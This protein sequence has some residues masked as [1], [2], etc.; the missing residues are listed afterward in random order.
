MPS[1]A[2]FRSISRLLI[3][4]IVVLALLCAV[5]LG[6]MQAL[7][8]WRFQQERFDRDVRVLAENSLKLLSTALWDIETLAVQNQV[9][10][11]A[12]LPEV[13]HVHVRS[14]TG[15]V[16]EA[17][18]QAC[19]AGKPAMV[20]LPI[21]AP[22]AR[23]V[24]GELEI[25]GN[26]DSF[27]AQALRRVFYLLGGYVVF[28]LLVC[29]MVAW[30]LRRQLQDPLEQMRRFVADLRPQALSTPLNLVR[31]H[32]SYTDEID[33]MARGFQRLQESVRRHIVLLDA[34]VLERTVQLEA[35]V[36]EVRRLSML[37]A[38]TGCYNRRAL[39]ERLPAEVERSHRYQRP[40][41]VVFLDVDHFKRINDELGHVS[42]D[43]VLR[44]I[45]QR[46]M[47][48]LR[49]QV[50]WVARYGG[51]EFVIVLP[52]SD[53]QAAWAFAER[54]RSRIRSTPI[55][56]VRAQTIT[57]SLGVAQLRAEESMADLLARAD[58]LLYQAKKEGRDRVLGASRHG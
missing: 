2:P 6:G 21:L 27:A 38:L 7:I 40:L 51:E 54:L 32:S 26:T 3:Q 50:D 12:H 15:P 44:E 55:V 31:R 30:V 34:R 18:D 8:E 52:E 35:S 16:F 43:A 33:V 37:D 13:G 48:S 9:D 49:S 53:A 20:V 25:W 23:T 4:R 47:Q 29:S 11:L 22:E 5:L 36:E 28:T 56:V 45:A 58:A 42:G 19:E 14:L 10:W 46:C 39:D 41:S 17:G 1:I 57:A 24:I